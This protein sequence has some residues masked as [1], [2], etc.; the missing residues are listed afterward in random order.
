MFLFLVSLLVGYAPDPVAIYH[1]NVTENK[2]GLLVEV[3][4]PA[5][6][7]P[8][9][10]RLIHLKTT[11]IKRL[12]I[13]AMAKLGDHSAYTAIVLDSEWSPCGIS[14]EVRVEVLIGDTWREVGVARVKNGKPR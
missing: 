13:A 5:S 6:V 9:E 8:K 12:A 10:V 11:K 1:T 7:V 14:D 2:P 4:L 3:N